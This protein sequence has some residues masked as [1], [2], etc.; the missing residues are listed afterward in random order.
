V[1]ATENLIHR[2]ALDPSD[3]WHDISDCACRE[4]GKLPNMQHMHSKG[5]RIALV[6]STT[7][8]PSPLTLLDGRWY[9]EQVMGFSSRL[10]GSAYI[11]IQLTV[12]S[13]ET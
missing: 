11:A 2:L 7:V 12:C 5:R 8:L 6:P 9:S 1:L 4:Q 13:K 3:W 10:A